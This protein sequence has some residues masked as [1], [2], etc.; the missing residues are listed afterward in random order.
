M[1]TWDLHAL[2]GNFSFTPAMAY[3]CCSLIVWSS[4][5]ELQQAAA[6]FKHSL[7]QRPGQESRLEI[8]R[9]KSRILKRLLEKKNGLHA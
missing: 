3:S 5:A 8:W 6:M 9:P 4:P 1:A 7:K 2:Q